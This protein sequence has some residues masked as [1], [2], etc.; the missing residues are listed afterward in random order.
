MT[1]LKKKISEKNPQ[2]S[3]KTIF[4]SKHMA[5]NFTWF[6]HEHE[7][8]Q[9]QAKKSTNKKFIYLTENMIVIIDLAHFIV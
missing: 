1:T 8:K 5:T 2:Q 7:Y 3:K 4:Y 6:T 9:K